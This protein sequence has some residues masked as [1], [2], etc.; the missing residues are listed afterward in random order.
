MIEEKTIANDIRPLSFRGSNAVLPNLR[1]ATDSGR[2]ANEDN[3]ESQ[4]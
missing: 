1:P 4:R 2:K 3:I